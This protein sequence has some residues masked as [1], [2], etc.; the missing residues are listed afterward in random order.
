MISSYGV[1]P[2]CKA[3]EYRRHGPEHLVQDG[4]VHRAGL[5]RLLNKLLS[6][7]LGFELNQK[8]ACGIGCGSCRTMPAVPM[9]PGSGCE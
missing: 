3:R 5:L 7:V 4:R 8:F 2:R 1:Y 6:L 9:K